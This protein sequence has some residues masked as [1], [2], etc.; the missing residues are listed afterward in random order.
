MNKKHTDKLNQW[1][2]KVKTSKERNYNFETV[3]GKNNELLYYPTEIS[4]KYIENLGFPGQYPYTRGIHPNLYR[5]KLWTMRQFAGF[6]SPKETNERFKFLLKNGQTGL[7]VAFDMPTLMGYDPNH[8]FSI[9]EVGHCGVSISNLEDMEILFD[10]IDLSTVSVSMTINGPAIIVFAFYVAVAKKQGV[11]ISQLRGTLQND[12]LKEYI[13][14]KEWIFP[15][16][17]SVRVITDMMSFCNS[18]MPKYNTISISGYHIREAGSTAAQELAFTLANG[19]TYVEHAMEAGLDVDDF[20]PRLSFFFNSHLDFF[21]EVAKYRAARRIWSKR[22]KEKYGAKLDKSLMLRFHTQT[23]GFSL[24]AQQP[25]INIARTSFQAL[26]AVMGGTQSL[27]TNS[28]DE[29][30]ALPSEKAAE[31][32]LRTQQ[33]IAFETGVT[34]VIDPLG[35]SWYVEE[36]TDSIEKDAL[37]YF[38]EIEKNGGVIEC[39]ESGYLQKEISDASS[40]YQIK[41]DN[42]ERII[43]GMT[44]FIKEN[45]EIEIPILEIR[46]EVEEEQN[47]RLNAI[48]SNRN[49]QDVEA[50]LLKIQECCKSGENLMPSIIKAVESYATL[51]EIVDSMKEVFGEWQEKVFF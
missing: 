36:L 17:E 5:G 44:E 25:E 37:E 45:E 6:G 46:K 32:A 40:D 30:L 51:G 31:I 13:A 7:S 43:V 12:I 9:G 41:I 39:I 11:D 1:K 38:D 3:S 50:S 2:D 34:N 19:F 20:A 14:Q 49:N 23:A 4:D 18:E 29:T 10:G 15:P 48:K 27:H 47:K 8:E 35:G 21:E 16:K 26:A 42:K 22:M 33:L 24:T 28:M